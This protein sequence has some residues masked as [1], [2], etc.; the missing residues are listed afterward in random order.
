MHRKIYKSFLKRKEAWFAIGA[1]FAFCIT[2]IIQLYAL[3]RTISVTNRSMSFAAASDLLDSWDRELF[4]SIEA[5]IAQKTF[6][7][8]GEERTNSTGYGWQDVNLYLNFLN[9]VALHYDNNVL[10]LETVDAL[11][12]AVILEAY[13]NSDVEA[14]VMQMRTNGSQEYAFIGFERLAKKLH[15]LSTRTKFVERFTEP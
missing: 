11:F 12:G 4:R 2:T 14:Y 6:F 8:N 9:T 13:L 15:S 5:E 3:N 7:F 10:D 1:I